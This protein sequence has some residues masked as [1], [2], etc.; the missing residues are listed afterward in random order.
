MLYVFCFN[1]FSFSFYVF[2]FV[3][4]VFC[5]LIF[6]FYALHFSFYVFH[7]SFYVFRFTFYVF[8]CLD[9]VFC[10]TLYVFC[11]TFYVFGEN[12]RFRRKFKI[13]RKLCFY[14][15]RFL[16]FMFN[17]FYVLRFW[18]FGFSNLN[19]NIAPKIPKKSEFLAANSN[20]DLDSIV[21]VVVGGHGDNIGTSSIGVSEFNQ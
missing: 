9:S 3:D 13:G 10:F 8:R 4:Y 21:G 20:R 11:F 7:F 14:V 5:F 12:F 1:V 2:C 6:L 15:L 19:L 16:C 17:V 18:V